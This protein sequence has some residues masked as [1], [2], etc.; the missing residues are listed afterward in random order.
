MLTTQPSPQE[1]LCDVSSHQREAKGAHSAARITRL[2]GPMFF[3][4]T[5]MMGRRCQGRRTYP[6]SA[7]CCVTVPGLVASL[8]SPRV[9]SVSQH[10]AS[11]G[12]KTMS[13]KAPSAPGLSGENSGRMQVTGSG[14]TH[15]GHAVSTFYPSPSSNH[16]AR[17][18]PESECRRKG[19]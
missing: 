14:P 16:T 11:F 15:A 12:T 10:T 6:R 8:T 2:S 5:C 4:E 9:M 18:A 13:N 1:G 19:K 7:S 17:T 3:V